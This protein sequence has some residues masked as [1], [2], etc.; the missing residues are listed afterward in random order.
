M[1]EYQPTNLLFIFA[2]QHNRRSLGCMGHPL[3]KTPNMDALA[4]RGT[5]FR[6]AY[7]N[8]PI[9]VPARASLATGR[10][11]FDIGK[12]DNCTPYQGV[13][14]SWGHRLADAGQRCVSIGKLHYRAQED[15]NGFEQSHLP[16]HILYGQGMLYTICR[17]PMP[18]MKKFGHL[19]HTSGEGESTYTQ[20]DHQITERT[21]QWLR[22]EGTKSDK[23]WAL[24][25]SLVCPHPP[26]NAPADFYRQYP[27]EDIDMPVNYGLDERPMHPGLEDYRQFFGVQ[28]TF[29]E[30]TLRR[31]I[32]SYYGMVTYL[33]DNLGK[34]VNALDACG[35]AANTR[36]VYTSDHGESMGQKGMFSKCN[37][38][39]ES[40]GIPMIMSGPGVPSGQQVD[41]PTQLVD[42]FPTVLE[43]TGVTPAE[44]DLELPGTS[45]LR[46]AGGE[47]PERVILSEQH[48]AGSRSAVFMVRDGRYKYVRYMH[49]GYAPHLYDLDADPT[50][51]D[52]LGTDPAHAGVVAACAAKLEGLM[53]PAAVDA[54]AKAHQA[55]LLEAGGGQEAVVAKGSPGYTPA[56]GEDPHFM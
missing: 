6:N 18:S 1:S 51:L 21:L 36:I 33:D 41:A 32:A 24:F 37:M 23:P 49:D 20:Y 45:L 55:E 48:S 34:I 16:M 4:E 22:E 30:E 47:R 43:S 26:W 8:G 15:P 35:L 28:D 31:V 17:D 53:D 9:C 56:P 14:P 46:M 19:V 11:V 52:D 3:V 38:F 39:E 29:D 50:E 54:A 2:D 40:V 25:V 12:W 27:L 10:H 44:E 13:E 5:L 7:T 42:L